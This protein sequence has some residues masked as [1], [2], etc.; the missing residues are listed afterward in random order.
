MKHPK[1]ISHMRSAALAGLLATMAASASYALIEG[2]ERI[3]PAD[4]GRATYPLMLPEY[5]AA[6]QTDAAG[7]KNRHWLTHQV[8]AGEN[9]EKIFSRYGLSDAD[10]QDVL[11]SGE[12]A[13]G[14]K[15]LSPGHQLKLRIQADGRL[16]KLVYR[17]NPGHAIVVSRRKS[18]ITAKI[19]A[20]PVDRELTRASATIN[21][22]LFYDGKRAGLSD[23]LILELAN[24]FG[25]DVDFALDLRDGDSFTVVYETLY[26]DGEP[27]GTGDILAA[28]FVNQ[29]KA[30][31]AFRYTD[32]QGRSDY[33]TANGQGLHKAFL[34]T[35]VEFSHI[36]S[37]FSLARKHPIL[38]TIRA[39]KGVDYAAP[40]GTP[41][42]STGNG[43]I[44][45]M[46]TQNGYGNAVVIEHGHNYSTLYG[47]L[48]R[49]AHWKKGDTVHQG[50]VIGYV[51][52]TGLATGPHLHY[53]FRVGGE[54]QDPLTV[55]LPQTEPLKSKPLAAFLQQTRPFLAELTRFRNVS[56]AQLD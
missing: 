11:G 36:S 21:T 46:G 20:K 31:Q 5:P 41:V 1:H 18:G 24:I 30:Y 10:L 52:Q 12:A 33:Y 3:A 19:S 32:E 13:H 38:N 50:E 54:H 48:S 8:R 25:W 53:E 28:E 47:H 34:R 44:A 2:E 40:S 49:F 26:V 39:H 16:K 35:P 42:R 17:Q 37:Y 43:R 45:F 4:T 9:L 15:A 29:G 23:K 51:G 14:L 6:A 56:V 22:S 27:I 7:K 55:A